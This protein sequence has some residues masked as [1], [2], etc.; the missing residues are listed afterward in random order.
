MEISGRKVDYQGKQT[1]VLDLIRK[2][3]QWV[4]DNIYDT[5][6]PS[7]KEIF[8]AITQK[9]PSTDIRIVEEDFMNT[10]LPYM[11]NEPIFQE[12]LLAKLVDELMSR[13]EKYNKSLGCWGSGYPYENYGLDSAAPIVPNINIHSFC[14]TLKNKLQYLKQKYKKGKQPSTDMCQSA[15]KVLE[16]IPAIEEQMKEHAVKYGEL[17]KGFFEDFNKWYKKREEAE[18]D[19][20]RFDHRYHQRGT[21]TFG[22]YSGRAISYVIKRDLGYIEWALRNKRDFTLEGDDLE[23]FI[24]KAGY[25][26][27][28]LNKESCS[29]VQLTELIEI[30]DYLV[31]TNSYCL[32]SIILEVGKLPETKDIM[33]VNTKYPG[34]AFSF[35][36]RGEKMFMGVKGNLDG[37]TADKADDDPA[38]IEKN[39][40]DDE[41]QSESYTVL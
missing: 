28:V 32:H 2:C 38:P 10:L 1:F 31:G 41:N 12:P 4:Y 17:L 21:M 33:E 36:K 35:E 16:N 26:P 9:Y 19:L 39:P 6:E 3:P 25:N 23:E 34:L 37:I 29:I 11:M 14:F 20:R 7:E 24:E 27:V 22:K 8:D 18:W 30:M 13:I 5:L 15:E 40:T